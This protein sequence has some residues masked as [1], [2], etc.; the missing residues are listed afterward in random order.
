MDA[1]DPVM[2]PYLLNDSPPVG[3]T[4]DG[5]FIFKINPSDDQLSL[6]KDDSGIWIYNGYWNRD[7]DLFDDE[8]S[9]D[10]MW[11]IYWRNRSDP[12]YHKNTFFFGKPKGTDG[13]AVIRGVYAAALSYRDLNART[14]S[15]SEMSAFARR[16][17]GNSVKNIPFPGIS[18][19]EGAS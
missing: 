14:L 10:E 5:I 1:A 6:K 9:S 13:R 12:S 19:S 17:P 8:N 4:E 18:Q 15:G 7:V 16:P 2:S 3:F 11:Y